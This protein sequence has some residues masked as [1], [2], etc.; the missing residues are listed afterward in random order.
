[1]EVA[2]M[3]QSN[4]EDQQC[5]FDISNVITVCRCACKTLLM[6]EFGNSIGNDGCQ[7]QLGSLLPY[8][9]P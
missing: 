7:D 1:M 3:K 6:R 9:F 5:R 4:K 2:G 8:K